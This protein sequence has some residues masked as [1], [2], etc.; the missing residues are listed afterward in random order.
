[1]NKLIK[2]TKVFVRKN[3]TTILTTLGCAGVV[4]VGVTSAKGGMKYE[5]ENRRRL[6]QSPD[7][8]IMLAIDSFAPAVFLGVATIGCII[9]SNVVGKHQ[10]DV[11]SSAYMILD[12]SYKKYRD[13]VK[14]L[15]GDDIDRSIRKYIG[16]DEYT[17]CRYKSQDGTELFYDAISERYFESTRANVIQAQYDLN[18]DLAKTEM[19]CLND[20][21]KYLG[22]PEIEEDKYYGWSTFSHPVEVGHNWIDFR[23][24]E[25]EM[26]D[27]LTCT[28]IECSQDP[29]LDFDLF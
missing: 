1:M 18:K 29:H 6:N 22:I 27:G 24:H 7:E 19:V 9:G 2:Q 15:Y 25:M 23:F 28:L 13:R 16:N 21:Y 10:R 17:D 8:K 20:Y 26:E 11:I 4:G 3:S 5:R 14:E 12:S